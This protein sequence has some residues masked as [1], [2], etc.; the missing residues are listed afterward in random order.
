[1]R[2]Q[3]NFPELIISS[4]N[5]SSP[6]FVLLKRDRLKD[7]VGVF[8]SLCLMPEGEV[9][10]LFSLIYY[11]SCLMCRLNTFCIHTEFSAE[12]SGGNTKEYVVPALQDLT[13]LL[14]RQDKHGKS[15]N[16]GE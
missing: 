7:L 8:I 13:M 11:L 5:I 3:S 6:H 1:V 14:E 2:K 10:D 16:I 4:L 9:L 15:N 12:C